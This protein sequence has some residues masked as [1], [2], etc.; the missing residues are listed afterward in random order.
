MNGKGNRGL[1]ERAPNARWCWATAHQQLLDNG[2]LKELTVSPRSIEIGNPE[3]AEKLRTE[4]GYF[5]RD[6][7]RM[8]Y[9]WFRRLGLFVRSG[10]RPAYRILGL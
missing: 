5:H 10:A 1:V 4:T 3:L 9:P 2:K 6:A 7:L 8:H